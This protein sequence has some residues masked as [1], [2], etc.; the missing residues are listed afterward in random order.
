MIKLYFDDGGHPKGDGVVTFDDPFAAH[1]ASES[2][3]GT[4]PH[5]TSHV[6][7]VPEFNVGRTRCR[8]VLERCDVEG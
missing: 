4:L 8:R 2:F 3:N 1:K 6:V 7:Y 5:S